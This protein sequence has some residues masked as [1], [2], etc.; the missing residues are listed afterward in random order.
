MER[1]VKVTNGALLGV[2][3]WA[4]SRA[5]PSPPQ[6]CVYKKV[7]MSLFPDAQK[8]AVTVLIACCVLSGP[9]AN[10]HGTIEASCPRYRSSVVAS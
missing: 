2:K 9:G 10:G 8:V 5:D 6:A 3:P 4:P 1:V 7:E